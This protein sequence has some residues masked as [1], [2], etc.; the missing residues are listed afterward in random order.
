MTA[1]S[2][3][4]AGELQLVVPTS[5]STF[6]DRALSSAAPRLWNS[7]PIGVRRSTSLQIFKR[8]MKTYYFDYAFG[9]F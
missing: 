7:W 4:S 6:G 1:R 5:H 9:D 3:R 8:R 2:L